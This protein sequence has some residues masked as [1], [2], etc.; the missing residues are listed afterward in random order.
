MA[1]LRADHVRRHGLAALGAERQL[2]RRLAIV[3]TPAAGFLIRLTPLG[4]CHDNFLPI[5]NLQ[6]QLAAAPI[7]EN[8]VLDNLRSSLEQPDWNQSI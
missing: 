7:L 1:A 8:K 5:N 6:K 4:N 3:S 2:L